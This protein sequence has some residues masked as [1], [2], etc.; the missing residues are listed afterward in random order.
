M[1]DVA[2]V[3]LDVGGEVDGAWRVKD[4]HG[5]SVGCSRNGGF[6]GGHKVSA[7]VGIGTKGGTGEDG[8]RG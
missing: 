1:V 8:G 7:S 3:A 4:L 2:V 5:E 6:G